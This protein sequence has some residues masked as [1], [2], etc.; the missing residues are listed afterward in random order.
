MAENNTPPA[1]IGF[2]TVVEDVDH[3][4]FGGYLLLNA[5]GR[6]LE[7]HCT[8]PVKPNRAQEIL[9][10]PTLAPYLEGELI[11]ATLLG[12]AKSPPILVCTDRPAILA[13]RARIYCPV[14][15]ALKGDAEYPR[16]LARLVAGPNHVGAPPEDVRHV[17]S[18]AGLLAGLDLLE[19]FFRIREA[20][21]EARSTAVKTP[22]PAA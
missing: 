1:T 17:E 6:P 10:G 3:G 13:V 12:R 15:L 11:A 16:D 22:R 9:F 8:A 18:E 19:P 2:V 4:R 14:V 20:L 5:A 21:D 7:F